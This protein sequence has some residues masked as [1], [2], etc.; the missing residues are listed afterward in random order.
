MPPTKKKPKDD[1]RAIYQTIR[2]MLDNAEEEL[3]SERYSQLVERVGRDV[4]ARLDM[5]EGEDIEV[6][7]LD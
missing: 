3:S 5:L 4:N 7:E 6:E 2:D 1:T